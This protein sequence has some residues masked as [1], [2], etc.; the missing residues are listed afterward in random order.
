MKVVEWLQLALF[1]RI[2]GLQFSVHDS[3]VMLHYHGTLIEIE[4][5]RSRN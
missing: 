1:D 2:D 4:G 3:L 5:P